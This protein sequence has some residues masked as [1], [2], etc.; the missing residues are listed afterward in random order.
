[1]VETPPNLIGTAE[2]QLRGLYSYLFRLAENLNVALS[3][4]NEA[5]SS[6]Q[7]Q[8]VEGTDG[9]PDT[10]NELRVLIMNT[11]A[12]IMKE[13]EQLRT[14]MGDS[15]NEILTAWSAVQE[16]N[17][18]R[19]TALEDHAKACKEYQTETDTKL[20]QLGVKVDAVAEHQ[21]TA[22][23]YIA[24]DE[25]NGTMDISCAV[26]CAGLTVNGQALNDYIL[27]VVNAAAGEDEG[28]EGTQ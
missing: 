4:L 25:E 3:G 24:F 27:A 9:N 16:E 12:G 22:E 19:L 26:S 7:G 11:A 20:E 13:V 15:F 28:S 8:S 14:D 18:T 17:D 2:Q 23:K 5:E 1:M 21:A 6:A 10:Y